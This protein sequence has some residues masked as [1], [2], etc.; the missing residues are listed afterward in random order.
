VETR[1]KF[2]NF[3]L[4]RNI[5]ITF[6]FSTQIFV[7][8]NLNR[9]DCMKFAKKTEQKTIKTLLCKKFP[10]EKTVYDATDGPRP[11]SARTALCGTYYRALAALQPTNSRP[12]ARW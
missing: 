10:E 8:I 4:F 9:K 7:G 3:K 12:M 5:S 1:I 6:E 11:A 2:I